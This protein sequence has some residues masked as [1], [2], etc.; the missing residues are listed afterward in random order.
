VAPA[1]AFHPARPAR[2]TEIL[3]MKSGL[4]AKTF[5]LLAM[6]M[7]LC[8]VGVYAGKDMVVGL[9]GL[10][11][12]IIAFLGG[13][14]VTRIVAHF[15]TQI[16]LVCLGAWTFVTGLF[17]GPALAQYAHALN[18]GWAD[19]MVATAGTAGVAAVCG[20]VATFSG[21]NFSGLGRFL[22]IGLFGLIIVGVINCFVAF[23]H[24]VTIAYC[25]IGIVVFT[26]YFLV[27]FYRVAHDDDTWENAIDACMQLFL[28][29]IN[30][31]FYILKLW[32]EMQKKD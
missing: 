19:V 3:F 30:L 7:G 16:G 11:A 21:I 20:L 24:V 22:M 28:D 10:I 15:N 18:G 12:L 29:F 25:L 32:L 9:G 13:A 26:G 14:I 17:I 4:F 23:G 5:L 31:L 1:A 8:S 27:D 6:A 2:K